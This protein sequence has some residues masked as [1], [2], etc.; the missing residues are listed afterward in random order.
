MRARDAIRTASLALSLLL[1]AAGLAP[2]RAAAG[3]GGVP[4]AAAA[5]SLAGEPAKA[6]EPTPPAAIPLPAVIRSSE[7]G[8]RALARIGDKLEDDSALQEVTERL[9]KTRDLLAGMAPAF[10]PDRIGELP[11]QELGDMRQGLVRIDQQ[12]ARWD[13]RLEDAVRSLFASG[14][15][16]QHMEATWA[17]TEEAARTARAPGSVFARIR[18]LRARIHSMADRAQA[19]LGETLEVQDSVATLRTRIADWSVAAERADRARE[20]QL[21]EIESAPL[22]RVF[23]RPAPGAKLRDQVVRSLEFHAGTVRA[24]AAAEA[25]WLVALLVAFALLSVI[26]AKLARRFRARRAEDPALEAP[27]EVLRHPMAVALLLTLSTVSW[28]FPATPVTVAEIA[29]LAML[30]AFLRAMGRVLPG[31]VRRSVYGLAATFAASRLEVLIPEHSLLGRLLLL[32]VAAVALAGLLRELRLGAW[33]SELPTERWRRAVK[34]AAQAASVLFAVSVVSNVVGNVSLARR[35]SD[36]TLASAVVAVLLFGT[37]LVLQALYVGLLRMP[38][39]LHLGAIERHRELFVTRGKKYIRWLAIAGWVYASEATFRVTQPFAE[40][41]TSVVSKRLRVGGLDVSLGD[42]IAF[43]VT[44]WVSVLLA[45]LLTFLLEE[46]LEG[47]G[48][49]RGVPAAISKTTGYLVAGVGLGFAVLASGMEVTRFTV[50][51]G[52]LG[53]GIGFGLQNVVNNFVSGLILL[54]E[55]PVQVGDIV[56]V[57]TTSGAVSRIGIRS[58]TI[59]TF[60]GAEVVVPNANLISGELVNWTLSDRLRRVE[61]SLGVAYGSDPAKVIEILLAAARRFDGVLATPEPSALFTGFGAHALEFQLR[62]WTHRFD[63]YPT[64]ASDVRIELCARLAEAGVAVPFPQRD[65]HLVTVSPEAARALG[66]AREPPPV[67]GRPGESEG[68][69]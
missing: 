36:G 53:V 2:A 27:A 21:F 57:G 13:V 18:D 23:E 37:A 44:L 40:A 14:V 50:L 38:W 25:G 41:V 69:R 4:G 31:R 22:W 3:L 16:L 12:L 66:C 39:A 45:R 32:A 54:Y 1:F 24:F 29:L 64:L 59:R 6:S 56:E 67:P 49:P 47:R 65:L 9:P 30:P 7:D 26:V 28:I 46:G 68:G 61:L 58:S 20:E 42:L 17:L 60:P 51:L 10:G 33:K 62:F 8:Y 52:T 15:E 63:S 11:L 48:L 34:L 5:K 55:R 19:R 35:L 43:G